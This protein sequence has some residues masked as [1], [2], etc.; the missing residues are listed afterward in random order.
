MDYS[1]PYILYV[2]QMLP[3][4]H[5]KETI[6]AF[7]KIASQ[8]PDHKLVLV[9]KDKY[10]PPII[11]DL[12]RETNVRLG[13][14]R[15]LYVDYIESDQDLRALYGHA[16]LFVY[17]SSSEAFGLPPMEA[18]TSGVPIVVKEEELNHELFG[19]AAF[20]VKEDD[21]IDHIADVLA[22]GLTDEQHRA[23]CLEK[24]KELPNRFNW[25]NFANRFFQII[26]H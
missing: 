26:E 16:K 14:E 24:Y 25:R 12:V 13:G 23:Y 18:A 11:A 3:R 2:G 1:F 7:E 8:F 20:F 5:A 6:Q 10:N 15:I 22:K 9:G 19:D 21:N 4:R 17:I